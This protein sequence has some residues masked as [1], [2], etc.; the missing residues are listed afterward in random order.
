MGR[1]VAGETLTRAQAADVMACVMSGEATPAQIGALLTGLRMRGETE[2]EIAGFVSVMR[3]NAVKVPAGRHSVVDTCGTGGDEVDTFNVST[4]AAFVAAGAGVPVAKHGNRAVSSRCGSADVLEALGI[5]TTAS[6]ELV[7]RCIDEIG[8]GFLFA[9]ALHPAM[10]HA[11]GPRRELGM[12]TVFNVLGPL[13]NPA[14]ARR[15]VLGVYADH[16]VPLVAGALARIGCD[17]A[18]VVHGSC[19]MDEVSTVGPT[20]VAIV[21]GD[22]V[23]RTE[24]FPATF[25]LSQANLGD[26]AGADPVTSAAIL[27]GI[28]EGEEGPRADFVLANAACAIM[29]GGLAEDPLEA[30]ERARQSIA[31]GAALEKLERLREMTAEEGTA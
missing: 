13:T 14:G 20:S 3:D 6:P 1:I 31:S 5:G 16:L 24:W 4:A 18:F 29:A 17:R 30:V 10:R 23:A 12:R 22:E 7:G 15:Q 21:E 8:I 25:G 28:L 11:A 27:R 26:L 9:P 19:G 2:E